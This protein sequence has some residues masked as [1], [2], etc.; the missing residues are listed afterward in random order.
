M[1]T[2]DLN[3][4]LAAA[5]AAAVASGDLADDGGLSAALGLVAGTWR[6]APAEAGG[7]PGSYASTLPFALAHRLA[8]DPAQVAAA[9]ATALRE[10]PGFNQA[11]ISEISVTGGGY[12]SITV[13]PDALAQLAVR[14]SRAGPGCA[15]SQAMH[16]ARVSAPRDARL[17]GAHDWADAWH[18]MTAEQAGR[19]AEAAGA[20]VTWIPPVPGETVPAETAPVEAGPAEAGPAGTAAG[21]AGPVAEAVAYA[22]EDA[23]RFA[24]SRLVSGPAR[25][26][27]PG[28]DP[29]TVAAQHLGNPAYAVRYAHA[30]A[31]S[32][33]R[34]AVD[35]GLPEPDTERF[36][37]CLLAHPSE[38]VLL[39]AM[40]WL[41]ERAAGAARRRQ[42]HVVAAYLEDLAGRY[43]G[44]QEACPVMRPGSVPPRLLDGELI[45]A[46]LQLA[47][48]ARTALGTG[49]GLL[50]IAAPGRM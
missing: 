48:A 18:R 35:L 9:L 49:L 47:S 40:S 13:T 32:A 43:F 37:P 38:L 20:E 34:Q 6:P 17:A 45:Q 31:A 42:P 16:G 4:A 8:V 50:G 39:D 24:L 44:W 33:L 30:H 14:I 28:L 36:Q 25:P 5:V 3:A 12:L 22:G 29:Q 46:R 15:R 19:L 7:G 41:P 23:V 21:A 10:V 26:H 2:G 27:G 1:I 11:G